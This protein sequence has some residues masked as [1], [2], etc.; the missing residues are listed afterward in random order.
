MNKDR[1]IK[2]CSNPLTV[3]VGLLL[4]GLAIYAAAFPASFVFDDYGNIVDN[5][6]ITVNQLNPSTIIRF[7]RESTDNRPLAMLTFALNHAWQGLDADG[8]RLINILLHIVNGWLVFGLARLIPRSGDGKNGWGPCLAAMLWLTIPLH[9]QSVTYIVQRMNSLATLFYLLSLIG[10]IQARQRQRRGGGRGLTLLLFTGCVLAGLLGLAAKP[11]VITLP[12]FIFLY[13]WFF[14]QDL[15]RAWLKSNW[16]WPALASTLCLLIALCYFDGRPLHGISIG[17][18]DKPFTMGQRLLTQPRVALYYLSL[19][20][21]PHP[22]RL[23]L[24]YDFPLSKTMSDPAVTL[25]ALAALSALVLLAFWSARKHRLLSFAVL[26]FLG[27]LVVESSVM[28]LALIFEHRTYL[29]SV[30]PVMAAGLCLTDRSRRPVAVMA[31]L[32]AISL[33]GAIWTCQRN[34]VWRDKVS[35]WQDCLAKAPENP[36]ASHNLGLALDRDGRYQEAIVH[37]RR[38]LAIIAHQGASDQTETPNIHA[39]LGAVLFK[40]EQYA[41]ARR[42]LKQ[43][44]DSLWHSSTPDVPRI[45]GICK[46]LGMTDLRLENPA[47]ALAY[48]KQAL[49]LTISAAGATHPDTAEAYNNLGVAYESAGRTDAAAACYRR[50]LA[51]FRATLGEGH[52]DTLTARENLAG[53]RPAGPME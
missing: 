31:L 42:H 22:G 17:Y 26:W 35:L 14:F 38:S 13:E 52:P 36:R 29:P 1:L 2:F 9:T 34:L 53:L 46:Q 21:W 19:L 39:N 47:E 33:I 10:Y 23:T 40:T 12:M 41:E 3:T 15:S 32:A 49:A 20:A 37:Y 24:D 51:I 6:R 28:G 50:A 11:I 43:S 7:F 25:L 18:A 27:N 8:F 30:L 4:I 45:A 44:L 5:P 48:F 16:R